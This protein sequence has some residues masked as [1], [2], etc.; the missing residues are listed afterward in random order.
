MITRVDRRH[1][2]DNK[3]AADEE[4]RGLL[5]LE[6]WREGIYSLDAG[7]LDEFCIHHERR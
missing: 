3:P 1:H 2:H 7:R 6:R 4:S 5:M